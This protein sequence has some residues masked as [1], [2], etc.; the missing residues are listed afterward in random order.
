M[1]KS[2]MYLVVSVHSAEIEHFHHH[3]K[4]YWGVPIV[5]QWKQI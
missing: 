1:L 4:Y 2:H 5:D 3:R